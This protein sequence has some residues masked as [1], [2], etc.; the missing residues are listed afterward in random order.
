MEQKTS[1]LS[2]NFRYGAE[3]S[4]R[5]ANPFNAGPMDGPDNKVM[6]YTSKFSKFSE[7]KPLDPNNK[8]TSLGLGAGKANQPT[9]PPLTTNISDIF[10]GGNQ[11]DGKPK[12]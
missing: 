1:T 11:Y 5:F 6:K 12:G 4:T 10:F 7:C 2:N 8:S 3:E 9:A